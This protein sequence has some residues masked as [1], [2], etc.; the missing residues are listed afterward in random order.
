MSDPEAYEV[1]AIRYGSRQERHRH[2]NFITA[3]PHDGI[4]PLDY[5]V[6]ALVNERRTIVV[7]TGFDHAEAERRERQLFRLPREGLAMLSI[8]AA[9]VETVI[10]SHLH[11]D[12]AGTLDDF[13]QARFHVQE[14]E[15][16]YTTGPHM[17][18]EYFRYAYT[19]EHVCAM[20][21]RMF[22]GRVA[23]HRGAAEVAPG[24][25]VHH[26]GGHTMGMQCVRVLTKRGWVVLASDASHFYEN[27][28]TAS[29]FPI[30]Y[31][32]GD[33]LA[34]FTTMRG[35]AESDDHIIPGHDPQVMALYPA[36]RAGLEGIIA[37]LDVAPMG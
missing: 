4:M 33:M 20:V 34:G 10:V 14:L 35:L 37:R 23:F 19:A 13:P 17:C 12:H 30:V 36:P 6:W 2:E 7:D 15:M 31:N 1:F 28:Q 32:V 25:S 29:P 27:M 18:E 11:Y 8:E 5:Y 9:A 16:S 3:D 24:V 26:I 22:E 21:R